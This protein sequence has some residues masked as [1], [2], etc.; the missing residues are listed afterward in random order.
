MFE[1]LT[2]RAL[3]SLNALRAFEAM[4]RTGSATR[5]AEELN[6]THSAVSRQVK[7]LE[8]S[9]D[10][11]LFTGPRHRLTL[12]PAGAELLGGLTEGFDRIAAAVLGVRSHSDHLMIAVHSSLSVKWLIPRL[13]RFAAANPGIGI[14]LIELAPAATGHRDA[15][16]TLRIRNGDTLDQ[17]GVTPIMPS[18]VGPVIA[19]SLAG[20][21]E[22]L[23]RLISRTHV[24]A[25]EEWEACGGRAL[26]PA[27]VRSF[28]HLH[29]TL[30]AAA[31]GLGVAVLPWAVVADDVAAG[32]LVAVDRFVPTDAA[33]ALAASDREPS[34]ALRRF[35]AWLVEEGAATPLP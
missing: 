2:A 17:P 29:V 13:S 5:A 22:R 27:P 12:T 21:W 10:L 7:A 26:P 6:V 1:N 20:D 25:W 28:A 16:A 14:E 35:T 24:A 30:D 31:A 19:A 9:L 4:A 3:P 33:V 15:H 34:R 11:R 23:P 8:A 32:R 18:L